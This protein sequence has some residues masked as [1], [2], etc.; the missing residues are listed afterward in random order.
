MT[1]EEMR[2][3]LGLG[4][5]VSAADVIAAYG[6]LPTAGPIVTLAEA[7]LWLRFSENEETHEDGTIELLIAAATEHV[8]TIAEAYDPMTPAPAALK[9]AVLAHIARA[10]DGREDGSDAP[11]GNM[12]LVQ[13]FRVLGV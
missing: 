12:R 1:V 13:S 11:A 6:A 2:L 3:A 7:K 10:F 9:L 4:A 8:L 5:D